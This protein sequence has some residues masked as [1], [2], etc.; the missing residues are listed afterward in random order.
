MSA[1]F[2]PK[3]GLRPTVRIRYASPPGNTPMARE[4]E[5]KLHIGAGDA[6]RLAHHPLLA[7]TTPNRKRLVSTYYD[8]PERDLQRY[9]IALRFRRIGR[10][11]LLTVK[12][13]DPA[14]GGLATRAEW[15]VPRAQ[16]DFDFSH[17]DDAGL[18]G[19]LET[20]RERLLPVFTSD[21]WRTAWTLNHGASTIE[22]A[23]DRGRLTA[24][25]RR[26]PISELEME[27]VGPGTPTDLLDLA[28]S[29]AA[30]ISLYPAPASKAERGYALFDD[31]P[32]V[33]V[34]ATSSKLPPR[35]TPLEAFRHLALDCLDHLQR[36]HG[37]LLDSSDPEFLHQSRVAI[38]RLRSLLGF[39]SPILP[40]AFTARYAPAWREVARAMGA[41]RDW[42]VLIGET[43]ERLP[44]A[45]IPESRLRRL[46]AAIRRERDSG[47]REMRA[48]LTQPGYG[49]FLLHFTN[50]LL[51]LQPPARIA[52]PTTLHAY[53]DARVAARLK[54]IRRALRRHGL[55]DESR[56]HALR[57]ALKKLRYA[58]E[59]FGTGLPAKLRK[60]LVRDA[61]STQ[62]TLGQLNDLLTARRLLAAFGGLA[63]GADQ[64]LA[65]EEGRLLTE[66]PHA[67][68][69][70]RR[71][72]AVRKD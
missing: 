4:I 32:S 17:V 47:L 65:A 48:L 62:Q 46:K 56:R 58:L 29:L 8:T 72:I 34:R 6:P 39:F 2:V 69:P 61:T 54:K 60:R 30:D 1:T 43:L 42:D 70:F 19:F 11:W 45:A 22:V 27:L 68:R 3:D 28:I 16:G 9:G 5:L 24:G 23:L 40:P 53:A 7:G 66:L 64:W 57:I 13:G 50:D 14:R 20:Q 36:N 51:A 18:R 67:A 31:R 21:F 37:G 25:D 55:A 26:E 10:D 59:F 41:S 12:G 52:Q 15:E 35:T 63:R 33:P 38:R 49:A 71:K 44:V